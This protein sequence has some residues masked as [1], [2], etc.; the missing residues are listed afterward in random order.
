[1]LD[2]IVACD[3]AVMLAEKNDH[4]GADTQTGK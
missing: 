1:V 4:D 3:R 2:V